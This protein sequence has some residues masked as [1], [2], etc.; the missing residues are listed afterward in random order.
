MGVPGLKRAFLAIV[1]PSEVLDAID[2][3]LERPKSSRFVWTRR[4]QW[5]FTLQFYGRVAD[6]D[7]LH[8]GDPRR[9]VRMGPGPAPGPGRRRVPEPEE[10]ARCSGSASR[11]R[12]R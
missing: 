6:V 3:L 10:R 5:H 2:G 9:R 7:G 1:P 4:D 8:D 12:T 11:M